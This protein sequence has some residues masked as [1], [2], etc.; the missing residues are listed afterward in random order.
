MATFNAIG[1]ASA[2]LGVT[3]DITITTGNLL[4]PTT[5]STVGTIKVNGAVFISSKGTASAFIGTNCGNLTNTGS[6]NFA[7]GNNALTG[8]TSGGRN[9]AIGGDGPLY[10]CTTSSH[11]I[12]I[13]TQA[14]VSLSTSTNGNNIGIGQNALNPSTTGEYNVAIGY[15]AGNSINTTGSSNI[16]LLNLGGSESN[17]IRIGTDGTGAGQQDAC[18]TAGA[19]TSA[20]GI[21]ATTGNI[22]TT[23]GNFLLPT[24]SATA[25][26]LQINSSQV[27]HN[28][29]TGDIFVGGA[30]NLTFTTANANYNTAVGS[31]ALAGI[32]GS[33]ATSDTRNVAIGYAAM[34]YK[35]N[36]GASTNANNVAIGAEAMGYNGSA[37]MTDNVAIG[38]L[39]GNHI[40]S[41][42][43]AIGTESL[44]G[45]GNG[46]ITNNVSIGYQATKAPGQN[47][48]NNVVVGYQA[49]ASSTSSPYDNVIIGYKACY[50]ETTGRPIG[51]VVIG[52]EANYSQNGGSNF[53]TLIGFRAGFGFT[54]NVE[55]SNI[56]IGY[57][58]TGTAGDQN[59]MRLGVSSGASDGQINK[60]FIAGIYGYAGTLG[61]TTAG[62]IIDSDNQLQTTY[63]VS[64][65]A[66]ARTF[67]FLKARGTGVI[68]SGDALG[69][70]KWSGHDGTG[71]IVGSQIT[72]TNSGTVATNRVASD[73][74]MYTHP[75]STTAS[76][77]RMTI[78]STGEVTIAAP[79]SGTGLTVGNGLTVSAGNTT[80]GTLL[81]TTVDTNVAAAGVT[82]AGTTL[83]ADGTDTDI[84]I[85][86][87]PKGA[88]TILS[89]AVYSKAVGATNRAMLVDDSGL[90]GNATSSRKFKENIINMGSNSSPIMNLRPVSFTYKADP[91]HHVKHG[92]IA[93]EVA[94]VMPSLVSY[95]EHHH[96]YTVSYH[97]L[98]ALLLNE[99][100][101]LN[102]RIE[103]LEQEL[104]VKD[105]R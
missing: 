38:S 5:S 80:V 99:I 102:K 51:C 97:E 67:N 21:T 48:Q 103:S 41:G 26:Q 72:S 50:G 58:V 3:G 85:T 28:Y 8:V 91:D 98:P 60:T 86:L 66:N 16:Y 94:E 17:K 95:D 47:T 83:A 22:T 63:A 78:A 84:N 12:A 29:G 43:I 15:N 77:L 44:K 36:I 34:R 24:T 65:D 4:L 54:T 32:T 13:G 49:L 2:P 42:N 45:G 11:N 35:A 56:S 40:A 37:V 74:K 33:S 70:I 57:N 105:L 62:V 55:S 25:G 89:T 81:V 27:L 52:K 101:K 31:L 92:L 64:A 75:D 18:Y 59:T 14:L 9:I 19:L 39:A 1:N 6:Y 104:A 68:T 10:S 23:T 73:L 76:T 96:P 46:N 61:A 90:I 53:N 20:R 82:L 30:G 7:C 69:Q 93:E 79:D 100:Q 88:G 71:L 87:T